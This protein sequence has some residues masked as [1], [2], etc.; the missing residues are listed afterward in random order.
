MFNRH[1]V[2][3]SR[4]EFLSDVPFFEGLSNKALAHL[5]AHLDDV[6]V[7]AG[8]VL[9]EQGRGAFETFIV[10]DGVAEV[11]VDDRVVGETSVGDLIGEIGVMQDHLRTATVVAKTPMRLLV[12]KSG[13]LGALIRENPTLAERTQASL[14]QHL[15]GPQQS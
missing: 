4:L 10:A 2:P 6:S 9:T 5:D 13:E 1:G 12:V 15:A 7:E 14:D 3:R 8:R 11:R